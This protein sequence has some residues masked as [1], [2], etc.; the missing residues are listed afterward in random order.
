MH[1]EELGP[2][3]VRIAGGT[4]REGAGGGPAVVLLHGFGAPG[5]DL[6]SLHRVL[7][8]APGTRWVFPEGPLS[9]A[10]LGMPGG[11]AWWMIDIARFQQARS[12]EE[13]ESRMAEVPS[14]LAAAREAVIAM[15]DALDAKLHPSKVVLG[16]FSQGAMLAIDVALRTE[17]PLAGLVA[18][19]GALIAA[20]EWKAI[21]PKRAGTAVVQSHGTRDAILPFMAGERLRDA[22]KGAGL[23]HTW[24]QFAGGHEI[25]GQVVDAVGSF[26][27]T[28]LAP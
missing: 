26:L 12:P 8:A 13:V 14:G 19:S 1:V 9:L 2:L 11:R 27:E 4:D 17:R 28:R 6:A 25:P 21:A 20:S 15:L 10:S 18:M 24:V 16:G 3:T 23:S 22:L 7:R 5:D